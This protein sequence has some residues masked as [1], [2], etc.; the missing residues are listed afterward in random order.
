MQDQVLSVDGPTG[1]RAD[2]IEVKRMKDEMTSMKKKIMGMQSHCS[3]E[4]EV[5]FGCS[6]SSILCFVHRI[7]G[8]ICWFHPFCVKF[9]EYEAQSADIEKE[10]QDT[11]ASRKEMESSN[12]GKKCYN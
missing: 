4:K 5:K 7:R 6:F 1:D 2:S 10:L 9:T 11:M 8:P 3:F 12:E